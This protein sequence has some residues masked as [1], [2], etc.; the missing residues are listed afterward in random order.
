MDQFQAGG[1]PLLQE[2]REKVPWQLGCLGRASNS[3][4]QTLRAQRRHSSWRN[5]KSKQEYKN[6][7]A[8]C[9]EIPGMSCES[10]TSLV[11][12]QIKTFKSV[13]H[14]LRT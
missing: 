10:K 13:N 4:I 2:L 6:K 8:Q 12:Q 14:G 7:K 1:C 5:Y 9:G 11:W 3:W